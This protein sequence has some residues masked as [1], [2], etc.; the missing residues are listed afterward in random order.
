MSYTRIYPP[1]APR[2]AQRRFQ[3]GDRVVVVNAEP[4]INGYYGHI[5]DVIADDTKNPRR[6]GSVVVSFEGHINRPTRSKL[7]S[8]EYGMFDDEL[9]HAD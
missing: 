4:E 9:Q 1:E 7:L 6:K 3:V 2:P 5:T 8:G